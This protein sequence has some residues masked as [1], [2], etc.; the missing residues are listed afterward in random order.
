MHY[1][2]IRQV[3]PFLGLASALSTLYSLWWLN[4]SSRDFINPIPLVSFCTPWKH[5]KTSP[6]GIYLLKV[7]NKN[8]RTKC[9]IYSKLSI[10]TPE[11]NH[12][13]RSGLFIINLEHILHLV[14][15]F[16]LLGTYFASCSS[17]SIVNFEKVNAG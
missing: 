11:L 1:V 16:L 2:Q 5:Q 15:V 3:F 8:I 12:W 4:S 14:L 10:R 17:V 13:L 9:E 6:T 7:N